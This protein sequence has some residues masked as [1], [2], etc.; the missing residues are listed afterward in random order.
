M[1][2][3]KK[4]TILGSGVMGSGIAT[5]MVN[6]GF[7][8][9]YLLDIIPPKLTEE[10]VK[11][12]YTLDSEN[13]R[14]LIARKNLNNILQSKPPQIGSQK[15]AKYITIGNTVDD[16][17]K[18]VSESDWVIEVVPE[19][20]KIKNDTFKRIDSVRKPGS[21]ITSN[22]SGI[23]I[24]KM[25]EGCSYDLKQHF[26]VTHF[27]NPVRFMKLLEI[28]KGEDTKQEVLD[29]IVK[30]GEEKLGK[31]IVYS[32]DV[33]AFV[34]NRIGVYNMMFLMNQV[35]DY[36]IETINIVF[37]K[38]LGYGG[39]PF[40][41]CDLA[42]LD[43][44]YHVIKN[45]Y[46][47]TNDECHE[48][49]KT[50]EFLARLVESGRLGRKTG[51]GFFKREKVKGKKLDLIINP[52]TNE[53]APKKNPVVRSVIEAKKAKTL[54]GAIRL[55]YDSTDVG[56]E[57]Y[58]KTVNA[59][60]RYAFARAPE[61]SPEGMEGVDKAV[62]WGFNQEVGPGE[63]LD[64]IGVEKVVKNIEKEAQVPKLLEELYKTGKN[65]VYLEN[66]KKEELVFD[67]GK[68]YRR[69][70]RP[71][72]YS[73]FKEIAKN[74]ALIFEIKNGGRLY[75]TGDDVLALETT[76]KNGTITKEL[77]DAVR[78]ALEKVKDYRGLVIGNDL[79]NFSFGANLDM[80]LGYIL[81]GKTKLIE[82]VTKE[83]QMLN[84][85]IKYSKVPVVVAKKG[86]A[87]GGGCELGYGAHVRAAHDSFIGLV[88]FG[89]GLI[90]GGGGVKETL[91]RK[92]SKYSNKPGSKPLDYIREAFEQ[93]V[94]VKVAMS[95]HEAKE[96]GY[97]SEDDGI[98]MN[99]DFLLYDAKQD[100]IKLS[101][102]YQ[103]PKEAYVLLPGRDVKATLYVGIDLAVAGKQL[104]P[105]KVP[106]FIRKHL[107][108]VTKTLADVVS[109]G[110]IPYPGKGFSE[111]ELLEKERQAFL[112]LTTEMSSKE[113]FC[114]LQIASATLKKNPYSWALKSVKDSYSNKELTRK[115][116]L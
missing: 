13:I 47:N 61:I 53:Y 60:I 105:M 106:N 81:R 42:G 32:Y 66:E 48:T 86:M 21:I 101:D 51:A 4:V 71:E 87:L 93:I 5:H 38:K 90:P 110:D 49:F 107:E 89:V 108:M 19:I 44:L 112:R 3:I 96:L 98:T 33:P 20:V 17:D 11:K 111:L 103:P 72:K 2:E 62:K 104:P 8:E 29:T 43:T 55:M 109:G 6:S 68:S 80:M 10:Q 74:H 79:E 67:K 26:L 100:V 37:D 41:T 54:E 56:G 46:E 40:S 84:H 97:M 25:I 28:V 113:K 24:D 35:K 18:Y 27:F 52:E 59:V 7:E 15:L 39:K 78:L 36:G 58:K 1:M 14:N 102:N 92:Y 34:S 94:F 73:S 23:S 115:V 30:I 65:R 85:D 12:G 50:P 116:K 76:S 69:I 64:I 91:V 70:E 77:M 88:E 75:D 114:W 63:T 95:A 16:F 82:S 31:G 45:I 99:T 9:V 57:I 83:F 22:T